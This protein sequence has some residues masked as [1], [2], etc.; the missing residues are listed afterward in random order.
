MA[1]IAVKVEFVHD[2]EG[3]IVLIDLDKK[4]V[5]AVLAQRSNLLCRRSTIMPL[6]YRHGGGD[7]VLSSVLGRSCVKFGA[8]DAPMLCAHRSWFCA[9]KKIVC[10]VSIGV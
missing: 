10:M 3:S 2:G 1:G 8:I 5:I 7:V 4:K 6:L 9:P